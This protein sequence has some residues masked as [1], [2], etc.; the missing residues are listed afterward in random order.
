MDHFGA[1][2]DWAAEGKLCLISYNHV[3]EAP[4]TTAIHKERDVCWHTQIGFQVSTL[5]KKVPGLSEEMERILRINCWSLEEQVY[6]SKGEKRQ[7]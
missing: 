5:H 4:G 1:G 2:Q 3:A 7:R 6:I